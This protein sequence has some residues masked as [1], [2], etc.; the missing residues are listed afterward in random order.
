MEDPDTLLVRVGG[1]LKKVQLIGV[2]APE[3]TGRY[4]DHQCFDREAKAQAAAK[5]FS[6]K[7]EVILESDNVVGDKDIHNRNL[8]YVKLIDGTLLN[9]VL[10][11]DGLAKVY[12]PENKSL[13]YKEAFLKAEHEARKAGMGIWDQ[14]GCKGLF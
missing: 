14:N 11:R 3:L 1:K 2:D 10:L 13:K 8:R 7:R 12:N 4:K 5:Y 9:E 6:S